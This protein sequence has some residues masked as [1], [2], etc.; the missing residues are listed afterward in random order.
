MQLG[1]DARTHKKGGKGVL[2]SYHIQPILHA[3]CGTRLL[4]SL[5]TLNVHCYACP[6]LRARLMCADGIL[7]VNVPL[8][9]SVDKCQYLSPGQRTGGV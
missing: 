2:P 7:G 3:L 1:V 8:Y 6:Q 4:D 5:V 9:V